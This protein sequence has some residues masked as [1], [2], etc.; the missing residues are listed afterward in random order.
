MVSTVV[1]MFPG[2]GSPSSVS[3]GAIAFKADIISW[4]TLAVP[5]VKSFMTPSF[6]DCPEVVEEG[7][8][9]DCK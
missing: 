4:V 6:I 1:S 3:V 9:S 2:N 7:T 8:S 5:S